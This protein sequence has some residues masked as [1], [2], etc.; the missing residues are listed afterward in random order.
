M[1]L[2]SH[3]RFSCQQCGVELEHQQNICGSCLTLPPPFSFTYYVSSYQ[4]PIDKWVMELKFGKNVL[5]SRLFA[6]LMSPLVKNAQEPMI[7]VPVPLH[8]SRL[9]KRGYNQ[10]Y[11]IAK[12]IA[13][14]SKLKLDTSLKRIKKTEMQAQ[15]KFKERTKNVKG[16][17][18]LKQP[19]S[20]KHIIL[21]DDVMTTG[22]T[23]KECAKTLVK[24]GAQEVQILVFARKS[25]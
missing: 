10:A 20:S 24:A 15:L 2:L 11:E 6:E 7:L 25:L 22:N 23:L 12:E 8:K 16:A 13:K 17:F 21:V 3:P 5:M 1:S 14:L 9:R 19:L 18:Q 4:A